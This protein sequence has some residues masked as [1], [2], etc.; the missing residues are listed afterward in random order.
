MSEMEGRVMRSRTRPD[1]QHLTR[2]A[3]QRRAISLSMGC[4]LLVVLQV[5][6]AVRGWASAFGTHPTSTTVSCSPNPVSPGTAA[7]CRVSVRDSNPGINYQPM[8]VVTLTGSPADGVNPVSCT[9]EYGACTTAYTPAAA[10]PVSLTATYGGGAWERCE[11][12]P[13]GGCADTNGVW[14]SSSGTTTLSVIDAAGVGATTTHVS[15]SPSTVVQVADWPTTC[16]ATVTSDSGTVM[17]TGTVTFWDGGCASQACGAGMFDACFG[18]SPYS[19]GPDTCT[20]NAGSCQVALRPYCYPSYSIPNLSTCSWAGQE[21]IGA[22]YAGD[23]A[24]SS[25]SGTTTITSVTLLNIY[26]GFPLWCGL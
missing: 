2:A 8:G 19:C 11:T 17:P 18:T 23:D 9:L 14:R 4:V 22:T 10:G 15:C 16:T 12:Y 21:S 3:Y 26:C 25:S 13:P 24:H 6:V 5:G 20:L 1:G 7:A